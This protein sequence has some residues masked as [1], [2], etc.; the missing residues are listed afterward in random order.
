MVLEVAL[1]DVTDP[2]GFAAAYRGAHH[3]VAGAA[4]RDF[5]PPPVPPPGL[6]APNVR[7]G[8][9]RGRVST[10][11]RRRGSAAAWRTCGRQ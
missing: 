7:G 2:T 6:T 4:G 5:P 8:R 1:I 11:G 9:R 3:I 10:V